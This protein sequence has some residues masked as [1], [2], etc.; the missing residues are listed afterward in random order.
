MRS[1]SAHNPNRKAESEMEEDPSSTIQ[2]AEN[3][4]YIN[5]AISSETVAPAIGFIAG[6]N[7][8]QSCDQ[9]VLFINSCGGSL[10]EGFAL[11]SVIMASRIPV[12]TVAIGE[13]DSSALVIAMSGHSRL[14]AP[15]CSILSHQYSCGIGLTKFADIKA[16]TKDFELTAQKVIDHYVYCTGLSEE[17]VT[18]NLV[19]DLDV[20]LCAQE[21]VDFGMFDA[22]FVDMAQLVDF[23]EQEEQVPVDPLCE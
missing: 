10:S 3:M 7:A 22:L 6:A 15:S 14:V 5:G 21:A 17:I 13:C 1:V 2:A 18:Q 4:L 8:K 16:R 20:F 11:S 12:V 19:N 23:G 9:I